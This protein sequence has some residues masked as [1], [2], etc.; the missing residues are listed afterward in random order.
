MSERIKA[1][2]RALTSARQSVSLY[3]NA[4]EIPDLVGWWDASQMAGFS[5]SDQ[6]ANW[7]DLS[8]N[9][10]DATASGASRPRYLSNILNGLPGLEFDGNDNMV[11]GS[12]L[13]D[14]SFSGI[15]EG[16]LF[17]VF[18]IL[19]ADGLWGI[20]EINGAV[21]GFWNFDGNQAFMAVFRA[22]RASAIVTGQPTSG[23]HYHTVRS[24]P[25][26]AYDYRR[27]GSLDGEVAANWGV[28]TPVFFGFENVSNFLTGRIHEIRI[29]NRELTDAEVS[30]TEAGFREKW[31]L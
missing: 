25:A 6:V 14:V 8:G 16:T 31:G 17:A 12:D 26:N 18:T 28:A 2:T 7:P 1:S 9:G 21:D 29:Y 5:D 4:G 20:V 24:G 23:S 30:D 10:Y 15:T 3:H 22:V 13:V 19:N 27:N 11:A